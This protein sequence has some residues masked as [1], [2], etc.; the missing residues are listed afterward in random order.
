M[1]DEG[2]GGGQVGLGLPE[3]EGD[4]GGAGLAPTDLPPLAAAAR[5]HLR[6]SL[7]TADAAASAASPGGTRPISDEPARSNP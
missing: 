2:G 1:G 4:V 6:Q 7:A 5:D 3:G